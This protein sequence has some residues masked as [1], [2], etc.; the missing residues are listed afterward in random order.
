[1]TSKFGRPIPVVEVA[2]TNMPKKS[3]I[4]KYKVETDAK[5]ANFMI[6]F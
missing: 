1:M 2:T 4:R 6:S 3:P 5:K